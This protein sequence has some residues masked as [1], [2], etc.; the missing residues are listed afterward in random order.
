ML[1]KAEVD[2]HY[3][4]VR[5]K[6]DV[7]RLDVAMNNVFRMAVLQSAQCLSNQFSGV[8]FGV[9]Y[10][11]FLEMVEAVEELSVRAILHHKV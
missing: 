2:E 6:K 5:I 8:L 1:S 9:F 10:A 7:L 11:C 3:I 4:T